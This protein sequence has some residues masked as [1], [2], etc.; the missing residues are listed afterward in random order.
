VELSEKVQLISVA[1]PLQFESPPAL[2]PVVLLENVLLVIVIVLKFTMPPPHAAEFPDIVLL[3]IIAV[4][5]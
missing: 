4:P 3:V 5:A 1:V 2:V